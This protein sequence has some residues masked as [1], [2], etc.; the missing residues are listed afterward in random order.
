[1]TTQPDD[2]KS[3]DKKK[4]GEGIDNDFVV[5]TYTVKIRHL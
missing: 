5:I 3:D 2:E 4:V 1:M